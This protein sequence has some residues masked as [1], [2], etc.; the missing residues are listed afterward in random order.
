MK[1]KSIQTD[2]KSITQSSIAW[3]LQVGG[4]YGTVTGPR[5]IQDLLHI[6]RVTYYRWATGRVAAPYAALELLRL[7]AFGEPPGGRSA[8]WRGF[9]FIQDKLIT[10]DGRELSPADLKAVFFWRQMAFSKLD[11]PARR[12]LY[13]ELRAIYRQA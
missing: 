4:L 6:D 8:A 10:E 2:N 9:R 12:D 13:D 11:G 3:L 1:T 7:H 5:M